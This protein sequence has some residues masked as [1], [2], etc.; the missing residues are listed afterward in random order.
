MAQNDT[1]TAE[2]DCNTTPTAGNG[3]ETALVCPN[4]GGERFGYIQRQVYHGPAV[5]SDSGQRSVRPRKD[6]PVV[7]PDTDDMMCGG[8][9]NQYNLDDLVPKTDYNTK[10]EGDE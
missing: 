6:G 4:C 3:E 7:A 8:C 10:T 9:E 2:Q 1:T 5:Q